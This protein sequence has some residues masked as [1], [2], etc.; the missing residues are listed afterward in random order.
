MDHELHDILW[1]HHT[2][3]VGKYIARE[4]LQFGLWWF[5]FFND[6]NGCARACEVCQKIGKSSK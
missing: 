4:I 3:V 5:N 2:S 1:E 6:F